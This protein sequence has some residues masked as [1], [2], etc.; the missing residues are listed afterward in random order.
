MTNAWES[1]FPFSSEASGTI[2][3]LSLALFAQIL[4]YRAHWSWKFRRPALAGAELLRI[5]GTVAGSDAPGTPVLIVD[6]DGTELF[7]RPFV[8]RERSGRSS[9]VQPRGA[10]LE[11]GLFERLLGSRRGACVGDRLTLDG[12]LDEVPLGESLYRERATTPALDAFRIAR[13]AWPELAWLRYPA[14]AVGAVAI[15]ALFSW[16]GSMP[17]AD[18]ELDDIPDEAALVVLNSMSSSPGVEEDSPEA[19]ATEEEVVADKPVDPAPASSEDREAVRAAIRAHLPSLLDCYQPA[20]LAIAQGKRPPQVKAI[21]RFSIG[22]RGQVLSASAESAVPGD[23]AL[24]TC[25]EATL[26]RILFPPPRSKRI[27]SVTFPL[28]P[29]VAGF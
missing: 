7:S 5:R 9:L 19:P 4:A 18:A 28:L 6:R 15:L 8:L 26:R 20:L 11:M 24:T 1:L 23:A 2:F 22:L 16:V 14:L 25:L 13:G 27:V 10:V 12:F 21:L 3:L 29:H 17:S